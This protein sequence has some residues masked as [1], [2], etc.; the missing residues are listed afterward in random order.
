MEVEDLSRGVARGSPTGEELAPDAS[1]RQDELPPV[2]LM[3]G[4]RA[5]SPAMSAERERFRS[6]QERHVYRKPA[7][8]KFKAPLV[9]KYRTRDCALRA[10]GRHNPDTFR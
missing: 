7:K 8:N 10:I 6:A 2:N 3:P 5:P 4:A 1:T 9:A